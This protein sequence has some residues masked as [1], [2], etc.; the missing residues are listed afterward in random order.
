MGTRFNSFYTE[1]LHPFVKAMVGLL[2][3]AG[4]R[5]RRPAFA[6]FLYRSANQKYH[7]DISLLA[8]IASDVVEER[9]KNP[10]DKADLLNAMILNK[11]SKTG[12]HLSEDSIVNNMITFLIAGKYTVRRSTTV[13]GAHSLGIGHETTS[14]LLSFLFY[15]LL[16]NPEAYRR[17]QGEVDEIVGKGSITVKHVSKLRYIN[18]CLRETLRLHPTAPAFTVSPKQDEI[19]GGKYLVPKDTPVVC[20]IMAAHRDPAVYGEDAGAFKPE[21]MLDEPYSQLPP[22]SWKVGHSL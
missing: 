12:E 17:A 1:D 20:F 10:V 16:K 22:N 3:A 19:I 5:A 8:K 18:A 7:D 4:E 11:D 14:G 13:S 6:D 15:E 2:V 21:R 9:R